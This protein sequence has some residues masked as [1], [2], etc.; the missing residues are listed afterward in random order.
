M[1]LWR[2][3]VFLLC[4][5]QEAWIYKL[6]Q[7]SFQKLGL[8][9]VSQAM[10]SVRNIVIRT[11]P[12]YSPLNKQRWETLMLTRVSTARYLTPAKKMVLLNILKDAGGPVWGAYARVSAPKI[13]HWTDRYSWRKSTRPAAYQSIAA[14]ADRWHP[15]V[16]RSSL[17][18]L[19]GIENKSTMTC[20]ERRRIGFQRILATHLSSQKTWK[21]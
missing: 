14:V 20:K 6:S 17:R 1:R 2:H 8:T 10:K 12:S 18:D 16:R 11:Q 9:N 19:S 5:N 7:E 3:D 15:H 13:P 21:P 4:N